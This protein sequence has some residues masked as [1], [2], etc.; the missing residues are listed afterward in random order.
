MCLHIQAVDFS[1]TTK[2]VTTTAEMFEGLV[3]C[4]EVMMKL[5]EY[6]ATVKAS[7]KLGIDPLSS[8][9][10]N[11]LF[12]GSPGTGKT[13][14]ARRV[15]TLFESLG[16][17]A[18]DAVLECSAKDFTSGYNGGDASSKTREM[19]E[20]GLGQVLFIDEA[21]RQVLNHDLC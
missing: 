4:E 18:S 21:Y 20:K 10:L 9:E 2:S 16:L 5:K 8:F 19:F 15:G 6:Q 12:V 7:Q 13:T 11:F 17:L 14:V 1:P 3:G